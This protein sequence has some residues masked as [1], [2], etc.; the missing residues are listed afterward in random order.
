MFNFFPHRS[1][2]FSEAIVFFSI[3]SVNSRNYI[4]KGQDWPFLI[5]KFYNYKS[6]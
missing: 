4:F 1:I 3:I 5:V 6:L 2:T